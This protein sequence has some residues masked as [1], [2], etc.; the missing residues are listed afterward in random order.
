MEVQIAHTERFWSINDEFS[1]VSTLSSEVPI[2]EV[3]FD[4]P[5]NPT[6]ILLRG[7][8]WAERFFDFG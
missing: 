8:R 7:T 5:K 6:I 4:T 1:S 3:V 2:G